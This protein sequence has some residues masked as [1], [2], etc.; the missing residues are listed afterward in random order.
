MSAYVTC[1]RLRTLTIWIHEPHVDT[2]GVD[3][4]D[5]AAME[6]N[7]LLACPH[8]QSV[9]IRAHRDSVTTALDMKCFAELT[10][11][12]IEN[13]PSLHSRGLLRFKNCS[14]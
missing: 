11:I 13:L 2:W 8:L 10:E 6:A 4:V 5:W 3:E 1:A 14:K 7:L 9:D 12:M